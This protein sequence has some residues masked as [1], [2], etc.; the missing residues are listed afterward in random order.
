MSKIGTSVQAVAMNIP[1]GTFHG[2]TLIGAVVAAVT[3]FLTLA[4]ALPAWAMFLGWVGFNASA[5]TTREGVAN[6]AAF[7]LGI[8]FGAATGLLIAWLTP[9]FG[10][11]STPL[12][13][14]GDVVLVLSLRALPRIN[15]PLA[16]FLG[17]ISFFAAG[18][19][20]SLRL[21]AALAAAGVLG[22]IGAGIANVLQGRLA[23]AG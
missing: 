11:L 22:A 5:Q 23:H 21:L 16:Y 13:V 14:F 15:N 9:R 10:D 17:L 20:P 1:P 18:Q 4:A 7:L 2:I 6:L 8:V 3:T 12:A 19:P